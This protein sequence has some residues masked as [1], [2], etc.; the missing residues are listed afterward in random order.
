MTVLA[1]YVIC[2]FLAIILYFVVAKAVAEQ[3][4]L[5]ETEAQLK[6]LRK[7]NAKQWMS[8]HKNMKKI[9]TELSKF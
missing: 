1:S 6:H 5:R 7:E 3:T 4:L 8:L 9:G 2:I